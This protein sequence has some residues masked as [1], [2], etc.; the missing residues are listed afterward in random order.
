VADEV[1]GQCIACVAAPLSLKA[2]ILALLL[3]RL[4]DIFKPWPVSAGERLPGGWGI[5]T[6]DVIAGLLSA[7]LIAAARWQGLI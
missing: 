6:D 7:L 5:M 3:F 4:L 1:A 2:Y